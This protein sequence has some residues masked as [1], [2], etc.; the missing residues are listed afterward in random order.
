MLLRSRSAPTKVAALAVS[1]VIVVTV[2]VV[3]R[4]SMEPAGESL[5][6]AADVVTRACALDQDILT[7]LWRGHHPVTSEDVTMVPR[8][9]NYIGTFDLVSH[10]GPWD[11]LQRIPLV[12]YGPGHI[13]AS[14]DPL[15]GPANIVDVYATID[16]LLDVDLPQRDGR[17]LRRALAD[18]SV[19]PKLV[20][21]VVWD[22]AGR[23]TLERWPDRWPTLARL[24]RE[25]TSYLDATVGTSPSVTSA[26]HASLGTGAWPRTHRVTGNDLRQRGGALTEAFEGLSAEGLGVSTFADEADRAYDNESVVGLLG[27]TAWHVGMLGHGTALPE[28]DRDELG[29]IEYRSG[30]R[31]TG[32]DTHFSTPDHLAGR[33]SIEK[34]LLELDRRDG[35]S[36]ERWLGHDISLAREVTWLTYSNPAWA[37]MQ[38]ELLEEMIETGGYGA[39]A[40]PDFLLV[41]FKMT[42]LAAH[43]WALDSQESAEALEAQDEAL[44][45]LVE[46]LDEAVGEYVVVVTADH[47]SSASPHSTGAWPIVQDTLREDL[48]A[49][50]GVEESEDLVAE[51]SAFGLYLDYDV[52][53]DVGTT[54]EEV[55]AFLNGY[56]IAENWEGEELP[57]GYEDRGDERVF[58]ASFAKAQV[59]AVM[60]CA[61]GK[62]SPPKNARA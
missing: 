41:N 30:T 52:M 34:H 62:A 10:S 55:A 53:A 46:H 60:E 15:E 39:D 23:A 13:Q 12:L 11:Y 3:A 2:I 40:V 56:T 6:A 45:D 33:G 25:G 17:P 42:D 9:P 58:S 4:R 22:G 1:L 14:G 20:V 59:D 8:E 31:I 57:D 61:F 43:A 49:H 29:V 19:P 51:S 5:G 37:A 32:N 35:R 28:G 47:G 18:S 38:Q 27:W 16:E 24:E 48:D 54:A 44:G 36:D 7:R 50:F 26:V 21:V